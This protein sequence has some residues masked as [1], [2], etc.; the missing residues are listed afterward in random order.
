MH[1]QSSQR[2]KGI[3]GKEKVKKGRR[4][5]TRGR[6]KTLASREKTFRLISKL[7]ERPGESC[8]SKEKK[9][10]KVTGNTRNNPTGKT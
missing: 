4:K 1:E 8:A 7:C 10:E 3:E 5:D 9:T 6:T 2:E